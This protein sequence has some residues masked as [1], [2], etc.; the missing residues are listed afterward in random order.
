MRRPRVARQRRILARIVALLQACLL[1]SSAGQSPGRVDISDGFESPKL[2]VSWSAEKSLPGAVEIQSNIVRA[3]KSAILITLHP[4]DQL[5]DEKGT[6]LER[7]EV[8][9]ARELMSLEDADYAYSFSLF[10][11]PDFPIVPTRLVIA[12]WK[13]YCPSGRC[14]PDNPVL[15]LRYQAGEF[16]VALRAGAVTR[17]LFRTADEIRGRWLDFAFLIR[18]SRGSQGRVKASL[19]GRPI[20]DYTGPTAYSETS[21]YP[22]AGRFYFKTGLYRDRTAET[23]KIYVDEYRKKELPKDN[24]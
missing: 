4:G 17:T 22:P 20:A 13:Q 8:M 12:Q 19:N 24:L 9:E 23:M 6:I 10:L 14:D 21:G 3:G 7:A 16:R 2:G 18:F 1:A 15:A 11:P 5:E